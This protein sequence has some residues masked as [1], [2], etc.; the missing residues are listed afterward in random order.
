MRPAQ[1]LATGLLFFLLFMPVFTYVGDMRVECEV[2]KEA[3]C[4]DLGTTQAI[5]GVGL[6]F[7]FMLSVGG[8]YKMRIYSSGSK[9]G[10]FCT[11]CGSQGAQSSGLCFVCDAQMS[12]SYDP[13]LMQLSEDGQWVWNGAEW[14]PAQQQPQQPIQ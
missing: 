6:L 14:V 4:S 3:D 1:I 11:K 5:A 9:K 2:S 13:Q 10:K 7:G 8:A 12:N